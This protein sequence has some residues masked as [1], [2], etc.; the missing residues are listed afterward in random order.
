MYQFT[1]ACL[2][3]IEQ[4]D[5]E[6]ERLFEL[7]NETFELLQDDMLSDKYNQI[8]ALLKELG[9]YVATHFANEEA[10]MAAINDPEL[11]IQKKQHMEF[12]EKV[13]QWDFA[14][15]EELEEQDETLENL[16][17]Y[18]TRWLYHHILGSDIII[19]RMPPVEE[20]RKIEDPCVFTKEYM[21]GIPLL[22]AEHETLFE[23]IREAN[24][25]V[26]EELHADR[27][28]EIVALIEKLKNYTEEHFRDEEE[29]MESIGY[30][31]LEAQKMAHQAFESKLRE[32]DFEQ[33]DKNQQQYLEELVVFL[34]GWISNHIL[35]S[36][37]L[38]EEG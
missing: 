8:R 20:W 15:I 36:D 31:G 21:T 4:I 7:I 14:D 10:Y 38:I 18:L 24:A 16:L 23:I 3:G 29:Y 25:L 6:H 34:F 27:F 2:T 17:R 12:R 22:D 19:G 26:K 28:D 30:P 33:M 13:Y 1:D 32:V 37:K 5:R 9:D 35:R 11:E